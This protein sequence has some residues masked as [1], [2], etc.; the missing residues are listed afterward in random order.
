MMFMT[1]LQSKRKEK[2][3]SEL[4]QRIR[5]ARRNARL[6]QSELGK[7]LGLSDKSISAYEQGRSTPPLDKLK[8]IAE[9]TSYPFAYFTQEDAGESTLAAKLQSIER[10]LAEVKRLLKSKK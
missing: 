3:L 4:A 8:K 6:S 9:I 5:I 2:A 10:E 7:S 1:T